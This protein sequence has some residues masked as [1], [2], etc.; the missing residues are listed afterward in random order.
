MAPLR[1]R[2]PA[3]AEFFFSSRRGAPI[4]THFN[5]TSSG[6]SPEDSGLLLLIRGDTQ[7]MTGQG[8]VPGQA[9]IL[10]TCVQ[11]EGVLILTFG[12]PG[13]QAVHTCCPSERGS[14]G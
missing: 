13:L 7:L 12:T 2:I 11:N 3:S 4:T 9:R 14:P 10:T 5:F 8:R 6:G 1:G